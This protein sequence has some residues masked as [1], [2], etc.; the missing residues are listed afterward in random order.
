MIDMALTERRIRDSFRSAIWVIF[1]VKQL[2][3]YRID[4]I[5]SLPFPYL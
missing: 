3:Q 5:S 4:Y 1:L 2:L